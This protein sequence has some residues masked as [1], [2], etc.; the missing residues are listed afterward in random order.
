MD[1]NID[2][3]AAVSQPKIPITLKSLP[4][5]FAIIRHLHEPMTPMMQFRAM[6]ITDLDAVVAIERQVQFH[7]W[8]KQQFLESL[9]TASHC[10]VLEQA[11]QVIGFC[12]LQTV[13]DEANLLL[14]AIDPA[15]QGKGYGSKLLEQALAALGDRCVMVF[16]EVRISNQAAIGLYE[17][18]GFN[19]VGQRR[20]YYPSATGREDAA[21]M[22]LTRDNIFS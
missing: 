2:P 3:F 6:Q 11:G 5:D 22:A 16:L 8:T 17:K 13:V 14:M 21:V 12:I 7:P 18:L 20:G 4:K 19:Q 10:S 15:Q 9:T 1:C